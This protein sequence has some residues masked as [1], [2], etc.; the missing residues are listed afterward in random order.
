MS[1][2]YNFALGSFLFI[3]ILIGFYFAKKRIP[4]INNRIY[5]K[6]LLCAGASTLLDFLTAYHASTGAGSSSITV[7]YV[8]SIAFILTLQYCLPLFLKYILIYSGV[9]SSSNK[10]KN[11]AICLPYIAVFFLTLSAPLWQGGIFYLGAQGEYYRGSGHFML[12]V[13]TAFYLLASIITMIVNRKKFAAKTVISVSICTLLVLS[14]TIIQAFNMKLLITSSSV[15]LTVCCL[16]FV[17]QTPNKY[18]D[19]LT[20]NYN[21]VSIP[22]FL[23]EMYGSLSDFN[24]IVVSLRSFEKIS[25]TYSTD[26]SDKL[27]IEFS[28]ELNSAFRGSFIFRAYY[29]DFVV[30]DAERRY[31]LGSVQNRVDIIRSSYTIEDKTITLEPGVVMLRSE[32]YE[33]TTEIM[34]MVDYVIAEDIFGDNGVKCMS[35]EEMV[36]CKKMS[37]LESSIGNDIEFQNITFEYDTINESKRSAVG[38]QIYPVKPGGNTVGCSSEELFRA[39]EHS[40]TMPA[41]CRYIMRKAAALIKNHMFVEGGYNIVTVALPMFAFSEIGFADEMK[42]I[43]EKEGVECL[44]ICFEMSSFEQ[45]SDIQTLKENFAKLRS[46][47]FSLALSNFG[48]GYIDIPLIT[49]LEFDYLKI[50]G[51]LIRNASSDRKQAGFLSIIYGVFSCYPLKLI[52]SGIESKSEFDFANVFSVPYGQGAYFCERKQ[53][54]GI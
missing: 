42:S 14:S 21:H 22:G 9:F 12:Y 31:S 33:N 51:E 38:I 34:D 49:D 48:V 47:G 5:V 45:T 16:Y 4:N 53:L 8:M 32:D 11:F 29:K 36:Q 46:S 6:L 18:I 26:I 10:L 13:S 27:L 28:N 54:L 44:R 15:A 25:V 20:G 7:L 3:L 40:G 41:L 30:L 17:L 50:H 43:C 37:A 24:L 39:A 19:S 52:Q 23:D 35:N 2:N 1:I